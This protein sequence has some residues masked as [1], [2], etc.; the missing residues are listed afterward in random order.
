MRPSWLACTAR[1][2]DTPGRP[3]PPRNPGARASRL[4]ASLNPP[5]ALPA[6]AKPEKRAP[7]LAPLRQCPVR[8]SRPLPQADCS[9]PH[10][11]VARLLVKRQPYARP[12]ARRQGPASP[13]RRP[14]GEP[15]SRRVR[16]RFFLR[17]PGRAPGG[18]G[19]GRVE[20]SSS[21]SSSP[22]VGLV[23]VGACACLQDSRRTCGHGHGRRT[24]DGRSPL[25][26]AVSASRGSSGCGR[27]GRPCCVLV[28]CDGRLVDRSLFSSLGTLSRNRPA[29]ITQLGDMDLSW[30]SG[31]LA[32]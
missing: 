8:V 19:R 29:G 12:P 7:R 26:S 32:S 5:R 17:Q 22:R 1:T 25:L 20:S 24:T 11:S 10:A 23:M 18:R 3:D 31:E 9:R 30:E 16:T 13:T 4:I 15:S 21:S 2:R 6:A 27:A 28:N 14:C